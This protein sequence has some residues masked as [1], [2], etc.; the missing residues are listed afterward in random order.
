MQTLTRVRFHQVS[1]KETNADC[2][3]LLE[4]AE[5]RSQSKVDGVCLQSLRGMLEQEVVTKTTRGRVYRFFSST[6]TLGNKPFKCDDLKFNFYLTLRDYLIVKTND[7]ADFNDISLTVSEVAKEIIKSAIQAVETETND[8][9]P[10][11]QK[12]RVPLY[13]K[14][15]RTFKRKPFEINEAKLREALYALLSK[16]ER[17]KKI[18]NTIGNLLQFGNRLQ[19]E[20]VDRATIFL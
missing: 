18:F 1:A 8:N 20:A 6:V 3:A 2:I 14:L 4:Q 11:Q 12:P 10:I 15:T 19:E 7:M 17:V 9:L 16:G 5:G 13:K